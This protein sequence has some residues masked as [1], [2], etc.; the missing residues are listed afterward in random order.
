MNI[1]KVVS[2]DRRAP[3]VH[4][5]HQVEH[6]RSSTHRPSDTC[7]TC[8]RTD[9]LRGQTGPGKSRRKENPLENST[10]HNTNTTVVFVD[11]F[12]NVPEPSVLGA[13]LVPK[14]VTMLPGHHGA[15]FGL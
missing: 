5:V 6:F 11:P 7:C 10:L 3:G 8:I 2:L 9:Q 4:D 1:L 13:R 12:A 14:E 15:A